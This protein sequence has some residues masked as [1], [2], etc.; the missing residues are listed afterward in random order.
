MMTDSL[1]PR[2]AALSS[3]YRAMSGASFTQNC[4]DLRAGSPGGR[5]VSPRVVYEPAAL[6]A[7]LP[8]D[9]LERLQRDN[10]PEVYRQEYLGEFVDWSGVA[11]SRLMRCSSTVFRCPCRSGATRCSRPWIQRSSPALTTTQPARCFGRTIRSPIRAF[12]SWIGI[13]FKSRVRRW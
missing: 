2:E 4:T 11:F 1:T 7:Y 3:T 10:S 5:I 13:F 8:Q 6:V 9:E 12:T